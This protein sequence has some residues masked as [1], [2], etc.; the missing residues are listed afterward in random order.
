MYIRYLVYCVVFNKSLV[1]DSYFYVLLYFEEG[2]V[3]IFQ[4]LL[5]ILVWINLLLFVSKKYNFDRGKEIK[6]RLENQGCESQNFRVI[7]SLDWEL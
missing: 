2:I 3:R 6:K 1:N 4:N 7:E 5:N